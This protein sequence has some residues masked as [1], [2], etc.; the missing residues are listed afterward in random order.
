[1]INLK[2][3]S[4]IH[5][6]IL[7]ALFALL[8]NSCKKEK[9][10][11]PV[12][13]SFVKDID[14]NIYQTIKI[15]NQWW[16]AENLKV[17]RYNDSSQIM[18]IQPNGSSIAPDT[19]W[20]NKKTGAYCSFNNVKENIKTYGLL[21]NWYS[22][23][24]SRKIAPKGWHIPS[25]EEWKALEMYLGMS[26]NEVEKT[27]WRGSH[28]GEKLKTLKIG[29]TVEGAWTKYGD[30]WPT[31]ES[32]F[33]ALAGGCCMFDGKWSDPLDTKSTGF[34]WSKTT[35]GNEAWY[36]YLDYKNA[37]VFRYYGPKTYG[38]SVRCVMN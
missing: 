11:S 1:M 6:F 9:N 36:R 31:D 28:E 16:M 13:T 14:G 7:I 26:A 23:S 37:N 32:C 19:L 27:S 25:D 20:A 12:E 3:Y 33:N 30:I 35:K 38:F 17:T 5:T 24:D 22:I 8:A 21:Y 4:R 15:G 18:K 34:W 29:A 2:Y 10:V